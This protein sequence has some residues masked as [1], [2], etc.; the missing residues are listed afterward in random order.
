MKCSIYC[1][2]LS[3]RWNLP[4]E[5]LTKSTSDLYVKY[6]KL[7]VVRKDLTHNE[8]ESKLP[9][10]P[11]AFKER[12]LLY[13]LVA[14]DMDGTLLK[15]DLTIAPGTIDVIQR[16]VAQGAII[17]IATGRMFASAKQFAEQLKIDVP[18]ITYQGAL[19]QDLQSEK[20]LFE[21]LLS[22]DIGRR[23]IEIS[24]ERHVHLQV[25]QDDLLYGA[26]DNERLSLYAKKVQVPYTV[27][28][29][30]RAL[31]KKGFAKAIYIGDPAYLEEMQIELKELF[32]HRAHITKS[33]PYFLE[34]THPE[35]NKGFALRELA[36]HLNIPLSQTIGVGDNFNDTELLEVAGLGVAMGNAVEPLK[37]AADF[38][39]YTNNQE[40]VKHV[41]EKFVLNEIPA[42]QH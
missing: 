31:A 41:I 7:L 16:A 24:E 38:I 5:K 8:Y 10:W 11:V 20:V 3:R 37:Q 33:T 15:D 18:L 19:I 27:E 22:E 21:R 39:T 17:T 36:N 23:L 32:G 13:K 34:V 6:A 12:I 42:N 25:Y 4:Y 9:S 30:L 29:N 2:S 26:E 28:P 14:L 40:G 35:A 1:L